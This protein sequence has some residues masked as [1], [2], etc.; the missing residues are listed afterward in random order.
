MTLQQYLNLY[1]ETPKSFGKKA[2]I[3]WTQIYNY[4]KGKFPTPEKLIKIKDATKGAVTP[5][6]CL[7]TYIKTSEGDP[8]V[9]KE[10]FWNENIN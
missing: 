2:G 7:D 10:G 3:H 9:R 5:N 1:D 8:S 4:L 6:D